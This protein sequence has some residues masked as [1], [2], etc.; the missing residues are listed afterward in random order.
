[1]NL[2]EAFQSQPLDKKFRDHVGG[3]IKTVSDWLDEVRPED[4]YY[5]SESSRNYGKTV[6]T[7]I[8]SELAGVMF[9]EVK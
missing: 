7:V 1:M 2:V 3:K 9:T 6:L 4:G 5:V 8:V